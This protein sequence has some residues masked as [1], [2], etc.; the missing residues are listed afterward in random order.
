MKKLLVFWP[1]VGMLMS[2]QAFA[3]KEGGGGQIIDVNSTPQLA[4]FVTKAVCRY[5]DGT[6]VID[7]NPIFKTQFMDTIQN[8]NWYLSASV[9]HEARRLRFCFTGPLAFVPAVD[10]DNPAVYP[11]EPKLKQIAYRSGDMVYVDQDAF[12]VLPD[13]TRSAVL[14]HETMHSYFP[15]WL[16]S[17]QI[18]LRTFV[19]LLGQV[20]T[21]NV[22]DP[23]QLS[24]SIIDNEVDFPENTI[25][26]DGSRATIEFLLAGEDE[27]AQLLMTYKE[28]DSIIDFSQFTFLSGVDQRFFYVNPPEVVVETTVVKLLLKSDLAG[29]R[30]IILDPR[31]ARVHPANLALGIFDQLSPD[32]KS[33]LS[34]KEIIEKIYDI[35]F[36]GLQNPELD[37]AKDGQ[38]EVDMKTAQ[39]LGADLEG[40]S[41]LGINDPKSLPSSYRELAS[42]I[43]YQIKQKR[44]DLVQSIIGDGSALTDLLKLT[45]L[46]NSATQFNFNFKVE[47]YM[48]TRHLQRIAGQ[49][50]TEFHDYVRKNL[51][52][53]EYSQLQTLYPNI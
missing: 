5:E 2:S 10:P 43:I 50:Q 47:Q 49:I 35:L 23:N 8:L 3:V 36:E 7:E 31:L 42:Y 13:F 34:T 29:F 21:G 1:I 28:I 15:M 22:Q 18:K 17:R 11:Q 45:G 38:T 33:I 39:E 46:M 26:L 51:T 52:D 4:D 40:R 6:Q 19:K 27:R 48:A 16:E 20:V 32:K 12:K 44:W 24:Q 14:L 25:A 9:L 30:S 37:Y 41:I 53:D